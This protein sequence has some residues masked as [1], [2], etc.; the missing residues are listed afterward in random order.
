MGTMVL[1]WSVGECRERR[2][3]GDRTFNADAVS[4]WSEESAGYIRI[5]GPGRQG[6]QPAG[7]L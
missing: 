6:D 4:E 3:R 1:L 2:R 5:A 7:Q